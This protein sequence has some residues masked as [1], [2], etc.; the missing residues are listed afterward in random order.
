[1]PY[2]DVPGFYA[3]LAKLHS[4]DARALQWTILTGARTGEVIGA[5]FKGQIT[6]TPATWAEITDVSDA[7]GDGQ[8]TWIIPGGLDGHMKP[9]KTHRVPLTRQMPELI[10]QRREDDVPFRC[11]QSLGHI[12]DMIQNFLHRSF[13]L[14]PA[15][16]GIR[17]LTPRRPKGP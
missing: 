5:E 8:P 6:K 3:G 10:G 9:K 13:V 14:R 4:D 7:D 11:Q 15:A 16:E 17:S 2:R 12:V 1:M